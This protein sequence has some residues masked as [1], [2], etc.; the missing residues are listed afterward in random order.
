LPASSKHKLQALAKDELLASLNVP[1]SSGQEVVAD[2][3]EVLDELADQEL[4]VDESD[5]TKAQVEK[6]RRDTKRLLIIE[7]IL[8]TEKNYISCLETLNAVSMI[9]DNL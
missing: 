2:D 8:E 6:E 7:E 9:H 5:E 1:L 3:E 4:E